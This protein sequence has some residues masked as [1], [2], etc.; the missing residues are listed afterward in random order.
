LKKGEFMNKKLI[1]GTLIIIFLLVSCSGP[2]QSLSKVNPTQIQPSLSPTN[3]AIP[4]PSVVIGLANAVHVVQLADLGDPLLSHLSYSP[5]GK[6]LVTSTSVGIKIYDAS[7][8]TPIH[9][10]AAE[11]WTGTPVFSPDGKM[12]AYQTVDKNLVIM[13]ISTGQ[14]IQTISGPMAVYNSMAFSPDWKILATTSVGDNTAKL[15][16][17]ATGSLLQTLNG[18]TKPVTLLVFSPDGQTLATSSYDDTLKL[19]NVS[20]GKLLQTLTGHTQTSFTAVFT[21]TGKPWFPGRMTRPSG[22]GMLPLV[23]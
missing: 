3:T 12:V 21:L 6:W 10:S 22:S 7:T 4:A 11:S 1:P 16:D 2:A 13:D 9:P 17:V 8:L 20:D 23:N 18:H 5:D 14:V 19:W 15:W